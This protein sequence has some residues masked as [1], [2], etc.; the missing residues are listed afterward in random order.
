[1]EKYCIGILKGT[2]T[3]KRYGMMVRIGEPKGFVN[4]FKEGFKSADVKGQ[5]KKPNTVV[6]PVKGKPPGAN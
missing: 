2:N 5:A 6:E 1:L 4:A 3:V